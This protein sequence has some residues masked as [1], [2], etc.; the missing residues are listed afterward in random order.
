[1]GRGHL[2]FFS[3]PQAEILVDKKPGCRLWVGRQVSRD[4]ISRGP[5]VDNVGWLGEIIPFRFVAAPL[6]CSGA[7]G[8]F[9]L[10]LVGQRGGL[11]CREEEGCVGELW[12]PGSFLGFTPPTLHWAEAPSRDPVELD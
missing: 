11:R 10:A 9:S 7:S 8:N 3:G 4:S 1:M 12:V 6:T 2:A 5:L